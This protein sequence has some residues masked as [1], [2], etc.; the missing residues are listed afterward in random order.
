[1]TVTDPTLTTVLVFIMAALVL[2][3]TAGLLIALGKL[4]V[5]IRQTEQNLVRMTKMVHGRLE[6]A[7]ALLEHL[8]GVQ[9]HLEEIATH[10]NRFLDA[11]GEHIERTNDRLAGLLTTATTKVDESGRTLEYALAQFMRQTTQLSREVHYP[12]KRISA[13]LKGIQV[14]LRTFLSRDRHVPT[15]DEEAFI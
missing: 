12:A 5:Q 8:S 6:E 7:N 13:V 3:Q 2:I 1:M 4:T 15:Q 10:S 11:T 14:G 9:G